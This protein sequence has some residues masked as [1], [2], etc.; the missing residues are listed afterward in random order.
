MFFFDMNNNLKMTGSYFDLQPIRRFE[1][2]R[3]MLKR[4]E[5]LSTNIT[6]ISVSEYIDRLEAFEMKKTREYKDDTNKQ[7]I[8]G[9][10]F[11]FLL[12]EKS[13]SNKFLSENELKKV[14][15]QLTK[16]IAQGERSLKWFAC[17]HKK[18]NAKYIAIYMSDRE[19]YPHSEYAK[20]EKDLYQ[21][22]LTKRFCSSMDDNAVLIGSK[23]DFKK[24]RNG[25]KIRVDVTFKQRKAQR[26]RCKPEQWSNFLKQIHILYRSIIVEKY[27][28]LPGFGFERYDLG[29]VKDRY[30]R[31][32]FC[33]GNNVK[34]TIGQ[35]IT[36]TLEHFR[37]KSITINKWSDVAGLGVDRKETKDLIPL[38]VYKKIKGFFKKYER[39]FNK[40]S[41]HDSE[42]VE[43]VFL[44]TRADRAEDN[45]ILLQNE[46]ES[47][48]KE[49]KEA[50]IKEIEHG[51]F[52]NIQ[53][54]SES[55]QSGSI[56]LDHAFA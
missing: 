8:Y 52:K 45:L 14:I 36:E 12:P 23:G 39:R 41:W 24:D 26:F 48:L 11:L 16:A 37:S 46:A 35:L 1:T 38:E 7:P 31:R 49:L 53:V 43:H 34:E 13:K 9:Y 15:V 44:G 17:I 29:D 55:D 20:Y 6:D 3:K 30:Q 33:F 28:I 56:L 42:G 19:Y 21:N 10:S 2:I 22:Q 40:G 5:L 47:E 25:N 27:K 50:L 4:N 51:K 32:I 18:I 54:V